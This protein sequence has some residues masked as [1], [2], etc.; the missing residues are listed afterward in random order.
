MMDRKLKFTISWMATINCKRIDSLKVLKGRENWY[1]CHRGGAERRKWMEIL[2][3]IITVIS[4]TSDVYSS[5]YQT[6]VTF[7]NNTK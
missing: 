7:I 1:V 5:T 3:S 6:K 4:L 2:K